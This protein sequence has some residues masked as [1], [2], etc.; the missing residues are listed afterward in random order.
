MKYCHECIK[1]FFNQSSQNKF[2]ELTKFQLKKV[3]LAENKI[4][5][6]E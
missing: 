6:G 5:L 3:T 4:Y 2:I 1:I